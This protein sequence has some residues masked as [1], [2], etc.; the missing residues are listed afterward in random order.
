MT[1]RFVVLLLCCLVLFACS[2]PEENATAQYNE[3]RLA[4]VD[5]KRNDYEAALRK[6]VEKYPQTKTAST[7]ITELEEINAE[8]AAIELMRKLSQERAEQGM[9]VVKKL[10][11]SFV[12]NSQ[13]GELFVIYGEATNTGLKDKSGVK[14]IGRIYNQNNE[15]VKEQISK[16]GV[17]FDDQTLKTTSILL[18]NKQMELGEGTLLKTNSPQPFTIVFDNL[19]KDIKE[20]S[21]DVEGQ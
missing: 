6:I 14:L 18:M 9:V 20:F 7:A 19:S 15:I 8:K 21:V 17:Y 3:A 13:A 12:N 16:A 5:G 11:G 10:K 2:N 4:K 1:I